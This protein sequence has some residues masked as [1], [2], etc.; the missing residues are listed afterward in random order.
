MTERV[1]RLPPPNA[2]GN[3]HHAP[4]STARPLSVRVRRHPWRFAIVAVGLIAAANLLWFAG[5]SADTTDRTKVLP[6]AVSSVLPANGSLVSVQSPVSVD[7]RDDLTGV[8]VVDGVEIP[9]NELSRIPGLGE[10][11]FRPGKGQV[12]ERLEPGVHIASVV[13]WPQAK[14]RA[15]GTS[16]FTWSFR[17]G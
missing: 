11:S 17:T 4:P 8:L 1:V 14:P 16:T 3:G 7:L 6:N 13:Y 15:D 9:E 12:F 2:N 5:H 10:L